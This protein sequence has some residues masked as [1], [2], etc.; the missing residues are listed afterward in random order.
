MCASSA[1]S[2]TT[3]TIVPPVSSNFGLYSCDPT[4][5]AAVDDLRRANS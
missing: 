1:T 3:L 2:K 4:V 5:Q